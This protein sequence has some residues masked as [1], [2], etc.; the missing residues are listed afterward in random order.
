MQK[1]SSVLR[2]LR[3]RPSAAMLVAMTALFLS[4]AGAGYAAI[5]IPANTISNA[6]LKNNSVGTIK[7]RQNSVT[8]QKIAPGSVGVVRID[9][10]QI[11]QAIKNGCTTGGQAITAIAETGTVT[12]GPALPAAFNSGVGTSVALSSPTIAATVATYSL[13][14][15]STYMVQADPYITVTPETTGTS[16][17]HVVVSCTLSAGT[18]TTSTETRSVSLDV[19]QGSGN[20]Q[21]ASIPLTVMAPSTPTAMTTTV[22][23]TRTTSTGNPTVTGQAT[24]YALQ[25]ATSATT[26]AKAG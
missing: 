10:Q 14:G 5:Y 21:Y 25:T 9:K 8:Y 2:H 1:P 19:T 12:C 4:L 17:E 13:A 6:M 23:C 20:S 22:T 24:I 16:P 3:K 26:P 18:A 15:G 7:L 11:Q